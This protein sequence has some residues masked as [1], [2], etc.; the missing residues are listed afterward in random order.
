M[1]HM[2]ERVRA[3]IVVDGRVQGVGFRWFTRNAASAYGIRGWVRNRSGGSVEIEAE[4][5][6]AAVEA[7][8]E[9]VRQGPTFAR[10]ESV[11]VDW[12]SPKHDSTFEVTG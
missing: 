9:K 2:A 12:I 1:Y 8:L 3:H 11:S 10:V 6:R 7:F 5:D 4:A